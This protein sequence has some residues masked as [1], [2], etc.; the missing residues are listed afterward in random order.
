MGRVGGEGGKIAGGDSEEDRSNISQSFVQSSFGITTGESYLLDSGYGEGE[1][2]GAAVSRWHGAHQCHDGGGGL[3]H[4]GLS[5]T[6]TLP[7]SLL[8]G[9]RGKLCRDGVVALQVS[10]PT[11]LT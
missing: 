10:Q 8:W 9:Q 3:P 4:T 5:A 1:A 2:Q 11:Y 6:F 7:A